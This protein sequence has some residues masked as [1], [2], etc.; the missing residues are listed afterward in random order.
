MAENKRILMVTLEVRELLYD[1]QNKSYLTASS[2]EMDSSKGYASTSQMQA[3]DDEETTYQLSRSLMN[4]IGMLKGMLSEY[5]ADGEN[6]TDNLLNTDI[7]G[8]GQLTL[9]LLMPNN[10]NSTTASSV[11]NSIH[12][13]LVN[14][15]LGEWFA[16]TNKEDA[17]IYSTQATVALASIKQALNQR[18]R[19]SR[20]NR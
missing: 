12:S 6:C 9:S 3:S 16:I 5:L 18:I 13:Y 19:P 10:Y 1:I 17:S 7:E 15:A 2:K 8:K 11:G 20:P 14:M 4:A